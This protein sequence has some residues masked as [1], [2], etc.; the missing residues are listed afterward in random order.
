MRLRGSSGS[1]RG[2]SEP[3]VASADLTEYDLSGG[4]VERFEPRPKDKPV[5][6]RLPEA[7]LNVVRRQAARA[8]IPY[9]RY[10]RMP[11]EQAV[12]GGAKR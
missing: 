5:N 6:L 8:G 3:C 10:I 4:Q 11:L 12:G 9:Q 7:L 1:C 2:Q